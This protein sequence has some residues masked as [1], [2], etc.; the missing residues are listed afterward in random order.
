MDKEQILSN[1]LQTTTEFCRISDPVECQ[2]RLNIAID[3]ALKE[4]IDWQA[5]SELD[6]IQNDEYYWELF[7]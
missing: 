3:D 2:R 6:I 5:P 4:I 7:S 1:F